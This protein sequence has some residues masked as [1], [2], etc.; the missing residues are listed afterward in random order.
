MVSATICE[1]VTV[2]VKCLIHALACLVLVWFLF[3]CFMFAFTSMHMF[4]SVLCRSQSL[5]ISA[6]PIDN[7]EHDV[8]VRTDVP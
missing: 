4:V 3:L 7:S 5:V 2:A 8:Q 1:L 6:E